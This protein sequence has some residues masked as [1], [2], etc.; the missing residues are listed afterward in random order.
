MKNL[1]D[2]PLFIVII[3]KVIGVF[4]SVTFVNIQIIPCLRKIFRFFHLKTERTCYAWE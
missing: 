1:K 2:F 4:Q 3:S